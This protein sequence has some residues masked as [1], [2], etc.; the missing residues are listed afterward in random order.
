MRSVAQ[1]SIEQPIYTWILVL[2]CLVGGVVGIDSIGRLEDPAFPIKNVLIITAYAGASAEEVEQEVT[3]VIEAALQELP[4][5]EEITSKSVAGRS[6]VT[7]ELKEEF[8]ADETPQI[9][10]ELRRRVTEAAG[11]LPPGAGV[12]LVE[13]DFGD[14]YGF[15][16]AVH[17]PDYT[18]AEIRDMSRFMSLRLNNVPNVAK[19]QTAGE[20]YE[21]LYVEIDHGRFTRLGLSVDNLFSSISVENQV[22]PAGSV[23]YDG[24]RLRV[25][26]EMAFDSE[27]AVGDMRIGRPGSTEIL[28]LADIAT[29]SRE[30][31]EVPPQLIRHNG[32]PV[33]T[34]GVSVVPGK[35]VV[36]VGRAVDR[37]IQELLR[38]LPLGVEIDS[39]YAQHEVVDEAILEFLRNLGLSVVT[40][41]LA[42]CLFMG[43]RA[44]TVVGAVLLLTVLGTICIMS[45]A[46]IELQRISLG[47]LMIA[48]GMLVDNGIVVA[49]GMVI[50]VRKGLSPADAAG[51]SVQRTQFPLLG[52]TVIGIIAFGPISLSDDNAGHFLVSLFYVV[53]I[54]LLLSWVLAITVV[55]LFG[56]YLLRPGEPVA[57]DQLYAGRLYRPYRALLTFGVRRAWWMSLLILIIT[58]GCMWLFQF[59][60]QGFFPLTNTP[61]FYIDYRLPEGT[62][63]NTTAADVSEVETL[64]ADMP[65]IE[66]VTSFIGRGATRFTTIMNPE[67]PNSAYAQMVVRV[68]DVAQMNDIMTAVDDELV[69][70]RPDAE[71][72][73]SRAEFTPSGNSKIE[74]RFS[75]PDAA[76]LRDL[77]D[78]A[79]GIYLQHDLRDRKTDWRQPVLQ[80]VPKFDESRARV[81][82]VTRT[83]LSQALAFATYGV[84]VGLF[85][86]ADKLIPIVARAPADERGDV[87]DLLERQVWS[88]AQQRHIPMTQVV[89]ELALEPD[90]A[91]IYRRDRERTIQAQ[92]NPPFG[93]NAA[94]TLDRVRPDVEAIPLPPGYALEWGGEF[95]GSE[96]AN[97]SLTS[98][99]PIA[100]G[101]MF[102]ITILMFGRIRQPVVIWLTVPMTT[103][104]VVLGLLA[105]DLSFT[106]PSFLGYLSLSGMLIKNCIVLVDE[107]D[108]R[109]DEQGFA[110]ETL[111]EASVSRL[112]P[113]MLAAGTTIAG[114]APLLGDAFFLEMAVCIMSGLAFATL[115]TLLAVPVFYRVALGRRVSN[116]PAGS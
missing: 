85:R 65:G 71:I 81:A 75:G 64:I 88:P 36:E 42:L 86:D 79:L 59:V 7:V 5:L 32:R 58:I 95:E 29:I 15:M 57:E 80:L 96:E 89:A 99:I 28:R 24:R 39:I 94:R 115:I 35:N 40:V 67:Q 41:V 66:D 60:K 68:A 54:S 53:G 13:D 9:F 106:F 97:E 103:C 33:F 49:E 110:L 113:V 47:A 21:A 26:P 55:P 31:V 10:D 74:A 51:E 56:K 111:V 62:D 92:A 6:E 4:Y 87:E 44:G 45:I 18:P 82:G 76:V 108:K 14:V 72:Q 78:Q 73:I 16:Y 52:A 114:M 104:G 8:G 101:A 30:S 105:T 63:I 1:F 98:K 100:L 38:S 83:D 46:G 116:H 70:G 20:P 90:D 91:T 27:R 43:W 3:D 93:H 12:P 109:F 37:E 61:L 102:F 34:V 48:M 50:G 112:R 19:V 25:A 22:T 2:A 11:R 107:I 69:A 84:Q 77:A 23:A 17:A